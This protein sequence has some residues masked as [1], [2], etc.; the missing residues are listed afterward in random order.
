VADIVQQRGGEHG[1]A[2]LFT[3]VV[4]GLELVENAMGQMKRA[5]TVGKAR[6]LRALVSKEADAE[7]ADAAQALK[8]GRVDQSD[9]QLPAGRIGSEANYIMD[10]IPVYF[11]DDGECS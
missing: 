9:E 7:L 2:F 10:R 4:F 3:D 5:Q 6:M 8:L 1:G 11:F